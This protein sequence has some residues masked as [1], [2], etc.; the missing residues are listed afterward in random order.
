M[1]FQKNLDALPALLF[2]AGVCKLCSIKRHLQMQMQ[3]E[4]MDTLGSR[5]GA[6]SLVKRIPEA[7][8]TVVAAACQRRQQ[9][10]PDSQQALHLC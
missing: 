10:L 3:C 5:Q 8:T 2:A 1:M 9:S 6:K 7:T 4:L